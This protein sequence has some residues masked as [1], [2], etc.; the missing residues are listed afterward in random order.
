MNTLGQWIFVQSNRKY[1]LGSSELENV[2]LELR[3]VTAVSL[4]TG[5][6]IYL[7]KLVKVY[8]CASNETMSLLWDRNK[9]LWLL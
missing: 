4:N 3:L 6:G 1:A 5:S 2:L 8:I 7:I 9:G